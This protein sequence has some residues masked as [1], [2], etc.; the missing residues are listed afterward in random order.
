MAH[1]LMRGFERSGTIWWHQVYQWTVTHTHKH[2]EG[3]GVFQEHVK[4]NMWVTPCK[5]DMI[6][7][8]NRKWKVEVES[9]SSG[10]FTIN[11]RRFDLNGE[12]MVA[13]VDKWPN[14]LHVEHQQRFKMKMRD[15]HNDRDNTDTHTL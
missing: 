6:D 8:E 11:Q 5:L 10:T 4:L 9:K 15:V 7:E 3:T 14:A 12:D 2:S 13:L 1:L